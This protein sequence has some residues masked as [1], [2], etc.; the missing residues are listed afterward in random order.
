M[1]V[2]DQIMIN[3]NLYFLFSNEA[4]HRYQPH[5]IYLFLNISLGTR[6]IIFVDITLYLL[7]IGIINKY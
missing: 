5:L 6:T 2:I 3:F 7:S 4:Q 1:V